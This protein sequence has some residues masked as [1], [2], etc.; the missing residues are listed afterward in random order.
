M[1][2]HSYQSISWISVDGD[3]DGMRHFSLVSFDW[4]SISG[5]VQ[6]L[7]KMRAKQTDGEKTLWEQVQDDNRCKILNLA[8]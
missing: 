4:L 8:G 1:L 7:H 6:R 3:G 5:L 2:F